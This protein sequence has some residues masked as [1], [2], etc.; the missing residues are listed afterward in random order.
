[1][2]LLQKRRLVVSTKMSF[3]AR[4]A[5]LKKY[6]RNIKDEDLY[7]YQSREN[8]LEQCIRFCGYLELILLHERD[9]DKENL[10]MLEYVGLPELYYER[11][12][13]I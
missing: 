2:T 9:F 5:E 8:G 13:M 7:R 11:A 10:T 4:L 6:R 3:E 1:M 12:E